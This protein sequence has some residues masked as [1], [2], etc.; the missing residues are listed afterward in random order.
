MVNTIQGRSWQ[1]EKE[2]VA[3]SPRNLAHLILSRGAGE[4]IKI[5][6][7]LRR[8]RWNLKIPEKLFSMQCKVSET[9][10]MSQAE[11]Q[12]GDEDGVDC[13]VGDEDDGG[14]HKEQI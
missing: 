8:I 4:T 3:I 2:N 5:S 13:G 11:R 10:R 6:S 12:T 14:E 7:L 9:W 1:G